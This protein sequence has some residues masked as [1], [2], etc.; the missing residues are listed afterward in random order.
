[1]LPINIIPQSRAKSDKAGYLFLRWMMRK[2][3][4]KIEEDIKQMT[5][6]IM[7]YGQYV[8]KDGKV[9]KMENFIID[10]ERKE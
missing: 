1:M 6:D 2:N 3:R 8:M 7:L 4:K 9:V 5:H 10:P